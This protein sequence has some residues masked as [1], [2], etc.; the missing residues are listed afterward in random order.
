[1][2]LGLLTKLFKDFVFNGM[3]VIRL[4]FVIIL[5]GKKLWSMHI[6]P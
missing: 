6:A 3:S 1:M 4:V 2:G 5:K